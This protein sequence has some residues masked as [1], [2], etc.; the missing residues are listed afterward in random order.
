MFA[1]QSDGCDPIV[2]A[3]DAGERFAPLRAGARTV[4]SGLRVPRAVGDF[5]ILDA[6]RESGGKALRAREAELLPWMRRASAL[7]GLALC[8]ETA[9]C[10]AVLPELVRS[11]E[12]ARDADVVVFN[13]GAAQKYVEALARPLP[14]LG[15]PSDPAGIDWAAVAAGG[16]ALA[17][18]VRA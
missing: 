12:L 6:V 9:A 18:E 17:R 1:C 2:R 16:S 11:G 4:A 10:L 5:L 14:S 15:G 7:T 8:P 13:T 3:F